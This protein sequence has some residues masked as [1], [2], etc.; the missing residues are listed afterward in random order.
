M[1]K[2]KLD[3][4]R[5]DHIQLSIF[6][7][8][9]TAAMVGNINYINPVPSSA[10]FDAASD[11][12]AEKQDKISATETI[13]QTLRAER[14]G[15]RVS[16]EGN[17][18]SRGIYVDEASGG[19][20]AKILSAA[21][22]IQADATPTTSMEKPYEVS[23]TMGDNPGEI[24]LS[25]HAMPKAKSYLIERRDHSDTATPGV[26]VQVKVSTRSSATIPGLS[27]GAKHAFR[28]RA[29]GPNDLESPWSDEAICMAP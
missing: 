29:L 22:A 10:I 26:W 7:K 27:S 14:D 19:D 8:E 18:N 21:F 15:L 20:T 17:L 12:Y 28:I 11:N 16:L 24:D 6:A 1:S 13:L 4:Q 23:A 2:V 25:C 3:L 9:H 5:K